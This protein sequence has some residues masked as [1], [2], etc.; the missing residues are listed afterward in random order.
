M[1]LVLGAGL[2]GAEA[3]TRLKIP[4]VVG[5]I[6]IGLVVGGSVLGLLPIKLVDRLAPVNNFALGIIGFMIGGELDF[7]IFKK[8][9][10][11]IFTILFVEV[12]IT[13]GLVGLIVWFLTKKAHVALIFAA[14]ATAT[15]PAATVDV[16]WEF[17]SQGELTSTILA[18]VGLDDA[19]ALIVFG[20]AVAYAKVL[21]GFG[22][23]SLANVLLNPLME[24]GGSIV[25]GIAVGIGV[26]KIAKR[27][28]S[29]K[30]FLTLI[31]SA[32][33]VCCGIAGQ[34]HLSQIMTCMFVGITLANRFRRYSERAVRLMDVSVTPVYILFF[35]MIGAKLQIGLLHKMGWLGLA[36]IGARSAGK[37]SGAYLGARLSHAAD[38][39]RKYL[40]PALFSQAGVAVGLSIAVAHDFSRFNAAGQELGMLVINV[41]AATTFIVQIIGPPCVKYSITKA[42]EVG[43]AKL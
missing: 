37:L 28:R 6:M 33:M 25:L 27:A 3:F 14:L 9:G 24:I 26:G 18:I 1:G 2:F 17:Q 21:I 29:D 43:K 4:K 31:I 23:F 22:S 41:I 32:I 42:G 19:L 8:M 34:F 30:E 16:L 5:Y 11:S 20:F 38:T 10:K 35:I 40:G 39:V 7:S 13:F 15:A 12:F 36:Y